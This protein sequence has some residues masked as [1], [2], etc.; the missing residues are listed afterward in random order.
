MGA[1]DDEEV[2]EVTIEL[3]GKVSPEAFKEYKAQLKACLEKLRKMTDRGK[4]IKVRRVR[5]ALRKRK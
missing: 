4:R 3:E 5:T 2:Y 1:P